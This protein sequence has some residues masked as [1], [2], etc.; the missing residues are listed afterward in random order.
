MV[1]LG[2]HPYIHGVGKVRVGA[3]FLFQNDLVHLVVGLEHHLGVEVGNQAFEFHAH[4]GGVA[5]TSAV[6]GFQNNHGVFAVHD[7]VTGANFLSYF[8]KVLGLEKPLF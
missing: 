7:D 8:H 5:S 6:F 1:E 4:R 2:V 3:V